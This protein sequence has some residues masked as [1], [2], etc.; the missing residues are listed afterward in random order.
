MSD[1]QLTQIRKSIEML[2][3]NIQKKDGYN[4][5]VKRVVRER[6]SK[7]NLNIF[8]SCE[9]FIQKDTVIGETDLKY[10]NKNATFI[11]ICHLDNNS[12]IEL[13]RERLYA[14]VEKIIGIYYYLPPNS[15]MT[16]CTA[17]FAEA[18]S[19][20]PLGSEQS[21]SSGGL[22]ITVSVLYKQQRKDPSAK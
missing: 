12:D 22:A 17:T 5:N 8:P 9:V 4:T 6:I 10:K 18:I 16:G 14:D 11:I 21:K 2:L 19:F 7:E 15:D 3:K 20:V 1:S 13:E